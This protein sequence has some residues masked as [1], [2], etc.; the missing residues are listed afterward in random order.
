M[1]AVTLAAATL[2]ALSTPVL[3]GGPTI[4]EPDPMPEATAAP[5]DVHDWSGFYA[6]LGYGRA[7]G[8]LDYN[9][10]GFAYDLNSGTTRSL[11]AGYLMQRGNFVFGGELAYSRGNDIYA[12]GFPAENVGTMIDLKGKAGF[13]RDRAMFYGVLGLSKAVY[14]F[15]DSTGD[16]FDTTGVGYGLGVD[17]AV[18]QRVNLGIEY[19]A[20]KTKGDFGGADDADL[21][22]NS[23]S[24]RVGLSF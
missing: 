20:R 4:V 13:A 23:L 17:V 16:S 21:D 3:A 11:F 12:E 2:A 6:G 22:V 1:K 10:P 5:V 9:V 19:M 24:L 18:T 15:N 14:E 7:S 8:T